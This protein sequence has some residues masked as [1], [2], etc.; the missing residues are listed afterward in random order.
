MRTIH[1]LQVGCADAS[2]I[3]AGGATFLID[4]HDIDKHSSLLPSDKQLRGVF[5]T[6]QHNDHFSGLEYLKKHKYTIEHLVYSP[7]SRR[8]ND[9]SVE[10]NDWNNFNALVMH[11]TKQG[12]KTHQP[13]RQESWKKAW[14]ETNGVSFW[15]LGPP[16]AIA[17]ASTRTLHDACLVI[18]AHCGKRKC[19]FVGDASDKCLDAIASTTHLCDDILHASHHGSLEGADLGFIKK[20]NAQYTV[21]STQSGVYD[22]V[23]HPTALRRYKDNTEHKVYRTDEDGS[24]KWSF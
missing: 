18:K 5:I 6:H 1:H 21:I 11:F 8:T 10:A 2:V 24:I 14:W 22:N 15:M 3:K 9:S 19:L 23:P 7:Y 20:C 13:F 17:T 16:K 4:C 12:T